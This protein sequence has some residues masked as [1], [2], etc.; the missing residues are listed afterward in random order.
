AAV[1]ISVCRLLRI[2]R[3]AHIELRR[4]LSSLP[5]HLVPVPVRLGCLSCARRVPA[6]RA[7]ANWS[8]SVSYRDR[9]RADRL[10]MLLVLSPRASARCGRRILAAGSASII[11]SITLPQ[12][13]LQGLEIIRA[14]YRTVG[15]AANSA[16]IFAQ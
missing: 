13:R 12:P 3:T 6:C 4:V 2:R 9:E 10:G 16:H 15:L 8:L 14:R 11:Q 5:D 7:C 1:A